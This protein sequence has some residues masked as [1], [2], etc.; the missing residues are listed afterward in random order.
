MQ[1]MH[2]FISQLF[3]CS[4]IDWI[5]LLTGI[6][7]VV[8]ARYNKSSNFYFGII[9]VVCYAYSFYNGGLYAEAALNIYYLLISIYGLLLW[10]N[11][12]NAP[13]VAIHYATKHEWLITAIIL[14]ASFASAMFL[15][16]QYTDSTTPLADALVSAWAFAGSYLMARRAI[17]YWLIINVSNAIAIPLQWHKQLYLAAIYSALMFIIAIFGY[18]SW[19]AKQ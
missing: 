14:V 11:N 15:L 12:N 10:R 13:I 9:S 2:T 19:R 5:A 6:A 16:K 4:I 17:Q 3:S 1:L 8:L 18:S 7:Q